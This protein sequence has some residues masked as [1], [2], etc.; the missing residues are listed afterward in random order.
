MT[1]R[2]LAAAAT[3]LWLAG[4]PGPRQP[5]AADAAAYLGLAAGTTFSYAAGANLTETHDVKT[6]SIL[7]GDDV[8]FD[9]LAKQNGFEVDE[10]TLSIDVGVKDVK[11]ARFFDCITNC[12]QPSAPV[13]FLT[14]P[15]KSGQQH[16]TEVDVVQT[17]NGNPLPSTHE[18]HTLVVGD[19]SD[20]TV[21]AGTFTGFTVAWTRDQ[22][23]DVKTSVFVLVPR[24]GARGCD[25]AGPCDG[26]DKCVAAV[27]EKA[28]AADTDCKGT[29]TGNGTACGA[30]GV[31]IAPVTGVVQVQGFDGAQLQLQ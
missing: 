11:L 27:C 28:C 18:T 7:A 1:L 19:E 6:S 4:C 26:S 2:G 12:G 16:Q 23:G 21:P 29:G 9:V 8:V 24:P 15:L 14:V 10:R 20:V 13:D 17:H 5:T 25:D 3:V 31:C 30:D 22:D